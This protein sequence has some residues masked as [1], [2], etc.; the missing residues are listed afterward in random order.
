MSLMKGEQTC[1]QHL[2]SEDLGT[3]LMTMVGKVQENATKVQ[4]LEEAQKKLDSVPVTLARQDERLKNIEDSLGKMRKLGWGLLAIF[5]TFLASQ[6]Y[7]T[8]FRVQV[9]PLHS[10]P[11]PLSMPGK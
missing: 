1:M 6:A 11:P 2:T 8:W 5:L 9:M 10:S 7:A 4:V 3:A